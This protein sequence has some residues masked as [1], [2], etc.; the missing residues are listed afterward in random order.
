[1]WIYHAGI[2]AS[3]AIAT[4][5]S[6]HDEDD[7]NGNDGNDDDD[8]DEDDGMADNLEDD[9]G[10]VNN[11][12][13]IN[14][15]INLNKLDSVVRNLSSEFEEESHLMHLRNMVLEVSTVRQ[16][17][18]SSTTSQ[19]QPLLVVFDDHRPSCNSLASSCAVVVDDDVDLLKHLGQLVRSDKWQ[20]RASHT[21][22]T[23]PSSKNLFKCNN[24]KNKIGTSSSI[25]Q[26]HRHPSISHEST[27]N[28]L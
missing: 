11:H 22:V 18:P 6:E 5:E 19:V 16:W 15:N 21:S 7:D 12:H 27:P 28:H 24:E 14:N 26:H 3:Y 10:E 13:I 2:G 1:M 8:G 9:Y 4:A 20:K 17:K 23:T 25:T